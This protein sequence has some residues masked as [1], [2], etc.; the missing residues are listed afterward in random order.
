V[1]SAAEERARL[2]EAHRRVQ[3]LTVIGLRDNLTPA[4]RAAV[5]DWERSSR[6][7][8]KLAQKAVDHA[9]RWEEQGMGH[10]E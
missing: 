2:A 6:A 1:R 3:L 8:V 7:A 10:G 9:E 5:K 4:Q